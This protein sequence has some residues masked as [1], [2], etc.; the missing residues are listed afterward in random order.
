MHLICFQLWDVFSMT[1]DFYLHLFIKTESLFLIQVHI[2]S[3][4]EIRN[5]SVRKVGRW[6][7]RRFHTLSKKTSSTPNSGLGI[8]RQPTFPA[9]WD[10]GGSRCPLRAPAGRLLAAALGSWGA[11]LSNPAPRRPG[12]CRL[13]GVRFDCEVPLASLVTCLPIEGLELL[14]FGRI[15]LWY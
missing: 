10:L 13:I 7:F 2:Q 4:S 11:G 5:V 8:C 3:P 14:F 1:R 12:Q 6:T 15:I 9:R